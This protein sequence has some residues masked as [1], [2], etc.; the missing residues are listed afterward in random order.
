[1]PDLWNESFRGQKFCRACGLGLEKVEQLIADQNGLP[2]IKH[3]ATAGP[4]FDR[5]GTIEKWIARA[6]FALEPF[7][8]ALYSGPIIVI[9]MIKMA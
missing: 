8:A 3:R 7:S 4:Y 9:A 6:L 5:S 1:M 2:R